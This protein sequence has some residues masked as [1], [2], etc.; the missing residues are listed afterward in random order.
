MAQTGFALEG[1]LPVGHP[2]VEPYLLYDSATDTLGIREPAG[3]SIP[4]RALVWSLAFSPDGRRLAIGQ[5]GL[6]R[7]PSCLRLWDLAA[8]RNVLVQARPLAYRCVAFSPDGK[9]LAAGTF[10]CAVEMYRLSGDVAM[11]DRLWRDLSEPVNALAFLPGDRI[12]VGTWA[13]KIIYVRPTQQSQVIARYPGKIFALAASPD[14]ST[15][16]VGGEKGVIQLYDVDTGQCRAS[17]YGHDLAVESLDF[18][19]D[20]KHLA[21][22]SWDKTVRIWDVASGREEKRIA[23]SDHERLAVRFS[24]DGKT[25]ACGDGPPAIRHTE[26]SPCSVQIWDWAQATLLHALSGHTNSIYALAFSP[27]G[28]TLAS[29]SLDQSVKFWDVATGWLRETIV[30]GETA[31]SAGTDTATGTVGP[32][33][34]S[35][36]DPGFDLWARAPGDSAPRPEVALPH[37]EKVEA[38]S[39]AYSPDGKTLVTAGSNG[40]LIRWEVEKLPAGARLL[41]SFSPANAIAFSPD[42]RMFATANLD[43][44]VGLSSAEGGQLALLRG[45]DSGVRSVAF[46]PDGKRLASGSGDKTVK[47][48][49]VATKKLLSTTPAQSE[50]VNA[51]AFSPDGK[52]LAIGTG[53]WS[54]TRTGQVSLWDPKTGKGIFPVLE[55]RRDVKALAFSPDSKRLACASGSEEGAVAV[56]SLSVGD[57]ES[58]VGPLERLDCPTGATTVAFSPDGTILAAGQT[59]GKLRLWD[60]ASLAPLVSH[61]VPVHGDM[62]FDLAFAP[63]GKHVATASKDGM[64]KIWSLESLLQARSNSD[65]KEAERR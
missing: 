12:A 14:G 13:G 1:P 33:A 4:G 28:K 49:E 2:P 22:A 47:L 65:H 16:A 6:D 56:L 45:H 46:S 42:G 21:S 63:D 59:N 50:P 23:H 24:P 38:R 41:T 8:K 7:Q 30:P 40:V 61:P 32:P 19:S 5:Q 3:H 51:V 20:G 58:T 36:P 54:S 18:S 25:L 39:A 31:T 57:S 37:G 26:P 35:R 62:I 44:T 53:D 34:G 55:T 10:D 27:D 29:G 43:H 17:L 64:V 9:R 48:W 60:A 15:L 52:L 11:L